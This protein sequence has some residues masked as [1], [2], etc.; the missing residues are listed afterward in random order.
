[1][2]E[3]MQ[4]G[5]S[6]IYSSQ[7][8][9][10]TTANNI[11]NANTDGYSRQSVSVSTAGSERYGD[12]FIGK[13]STVTG[14][15]RA[16]DKFA[17]TENIMNTSQY[18]FAEEV[19]A[20]NSQLDMLLS[21]E[22][23]TATKPVL[24]VFASINDVA[25]NPNMLESRTMFL[26]SSEN[27]ANQYNRLYA[28]LESQYIGINNDISNTAKTITNLATDLSNVNS[29]I[30]AVLS[31][32]GENNANDLMDQRDR[33]ITKLSELVNV[34]VVPA[35]NGMVNVYMG[36]GQPLVVGGQALTI[37]PVNGDPD[38]SRKGM[39]ISANGRIIK[40]DAG[41]LGG[42]VG[43]MFE[44]RDNDIESAINQLGQNVIGLTHA[45]NEQQKQG[46]TLEGEIGENIFNDI[47]SL[48]T[49]QRRVL[50]HNDGLGNAQVSLRID[51]I[52]QLKPDEYKLEVASYTP[53]EQGAR[54][55]IEFKVTNSTT[56]VVQNLAP[57]DL[58]KTDRIDI[59][60]SGLSL[61]IG[62]I[63]AT[64]PIQ[65]G[66][67]FTLRPTRLAAHDISLEQRDPVKV[68]AADAEIK[69]VAADTNNGNAIFRTS[70]I[71]NP[72]DSLYMD[73]DNP[74][75]IVITGKSGGVI[76][77]DIVDK[78]GYP[79]T[80]PAGSENSYTPPKMVGQTLSGL[81]VKQ[82]PLT[83]KATFNL[84]GIEVEMFHGS[85]A[86]GDKF[87]LNY[88][89]TGDGDNRNMRKIAALQN[90]KT[91]NN[92]KSTIQDVYTGML[93]E[94]GTKTANAD[95]SMQSALI[96]KNQSSERME[97]VNG[98]NMDEEAS[99]LIQFQ[100]HYSAAARIISI[101]G[102][103]F[104]TILQSTG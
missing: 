78:N 92:N 17:F 70:A 99:N 88:N 50:A 32:S 47:N 24:E 11:A 39:A 2:A 83:G 49:M 71:N 84:A 51:D 43:A 53:G 90:Q 52:S 7:A 67:T 95:I 33:A 82:E 86:A 37:I 104:D 61:G 77:Y 87:T 14:I 25:D 13:G 85:P 26:Q 57:V 6:G 21:D 48:S 94:L 79:V 30:S 3:L 16:Y 10:N 20:Q 40:I 101:A 98:V 76:S 35:D 38:P 29:Q 91:M 74:L 59:P 31:S 97:N 60:H 27:M 4:I 44:T 34:S 102:E 68:A 12:Y 75:E 36:S 41:R 19:F 63:I 15:E 22:S 80:L 103:L 58:A 42:K 62:S 46:Q 1:M 18:G 55:V 81:T 73:G 54:G 8:S 96:I 56:G 28:N 9:L 66:K 100:Q 23:T 72:L 45:I 93:S 64:D 89:E 65:A 5:L 69:A